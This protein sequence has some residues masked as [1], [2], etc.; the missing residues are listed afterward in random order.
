MI[1][2]A[3]DL[4]IPGRFF[5]SFEEKGVFTALIIIDD[6]WDEMFF[7]EGDQWSVGEDFGPKDLA[8]V[9]AWDFLEEE[10]DRFAAFL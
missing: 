1:E 4:V 7:D 2:E 9:S 3:D 6:D 8:A 5:E 10:E